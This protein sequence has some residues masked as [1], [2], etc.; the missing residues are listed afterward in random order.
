MKITKRALV[1]AITVLLAGKAANANVRYDFTA[2]SSFPFQGSSYTGT[3]SVEVPDFIT[4]DTTLPVSSLLACSATSSTSGPVDCFSQSFYFDV[5]VGYD[6]VGFG[7]IANTVPPESPTLQ[8]YYYFGEGSFSTPGMYTSQIFGNDQAA[9]LVVSLVPS[10]PEPS[11]W[12]CVAVGLFCLQRAVRRR[13]TQ[14]LSLRSAA[15]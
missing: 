10:I 12:A 7:V 15:T 14:Q 5:S 6:T 1:T 4:A 9:T 8:I 3:F 11:T 13:G 2:L